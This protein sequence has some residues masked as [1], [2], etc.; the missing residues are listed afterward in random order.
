MQPDPSLGISVDFPEQDVRNGIKFAMQ[1][2]LDAR[3]VFVFPSAGR[4]YTKNGAPVTNPRLDRDGV[5]L[6]PLVKVLEIAPVEISD[7]DCA[8]EMNPP[9]RERESDQYVGPMRKTIALVTVFDVDWAR[10][11]GCRE[12]RIGEDRFL[13]DAE[14]DTTGLFGITFT[15]LKFIAVEDS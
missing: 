4:T 3:P 14:V 1:M 8:I 6:D 15:V 12:M 10:I 9:F 11:K 5:P 7:V 2:G 13:F